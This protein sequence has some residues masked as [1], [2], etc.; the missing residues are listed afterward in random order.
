HEPIGRQALAALAAGCAHAV[1]LRVNTPPLEVG[2]GPL[3]HHARPARARERTNL[4]KGL[5]RILFA[6][7]TLHALRFGLFLWNLAHYCS[8]V[9]RTRSP[10]LNPLHRSPEPKTGPRCGNAREAELLRG[11]RGNRGLS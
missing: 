3:R 9:R 11:H 1:A 7:Q 6:L 5:P 8:L 2:R 4:V 10:Q